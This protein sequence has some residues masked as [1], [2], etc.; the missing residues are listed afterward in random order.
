[1]PNAGGGLAL[2]RRGVVVGER[3]R[4]SIAPRTP[5]RRPTAGADQATAA[6]A[7]AVRRAGL[8]GR[9]TRLRSDQRC[10]PSVGARDA[11]L[12]LGDHPAR[13]R[14]GERRL[15]FGAAVTT[16]A[17]ESS[18][19]APLRRRRSARA[20]VVIEPRAPR[21]ESLAFTSSG[22]ARQPRL[23]G[24]GAPPSRWCA[25]GAPSRRRPARAGP[26][27]EQPDPRERR[28]ASFSRLRDHAAR[29]ARA[30]PSSAAAPN[31]ALRVSG[32]PPPAP[33]GRAPPAHA[34]AP[35]PRRCGPRRPVRR[36]RAARARARPRARP[37]RR[38]CR[39]RSSSPSD[40]GARP[41][42]S[43]A[44]P[45]RERRPLAS[46]RAPRATPSATALQNADRIVR[47]RRSSSA[48]ARSTALR[49]SCARSATGDSGVACSGGS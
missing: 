33:R 45:R 26:A 16:R 12:R 36:R 18:L 32:A 10:R 6:R 27:C 44:P 17:A 46:P 8:V 15:Q 19:A 31:S 21:R 5:R 29:R 43:R 42:R 38:P 48:S 47:A 13:P 24:R 7:A 11:Q 35:A 37:A 28:L 9:E 4:A 30:P 40:P 2:D 34:R 20:V 14:D 39:R 3:A 41:A 49:R 22:R 25:M 1:M 23:R